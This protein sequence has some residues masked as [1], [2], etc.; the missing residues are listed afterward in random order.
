MSDHYGVSTI[1]LVGAEGDEQQ[2]VRFLTLNF[3]IRPPPAGWGDF[4][5]QRMKLFYRNYMEKFDIIAFQEVFATGYFQGFGSDLRSNFID[6]A[7]KKGF[8][9]HVRSPFY[10]SGFFKIFKLQKPVLTD[11]GLVILSR[12]PIETDDF[13]AFENSASDDEFAKKGMLYAKINI[14]GRHLHV[15]DTHMQASYEP[16]DFETTSKVRENQIFQYQQFIR[17]NAKPEEGGGFLHRISNGIMRRVSS[18]IGGN[19][20]EEEEQQQGPR[21]AV[22]V[23]GNNIHP[24]C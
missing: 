4:L 9:H 15:F 22:M 18:W 13:E 23:A 16:D 24:L 10:K 2:E 14:N 12:Y 6:A 8:E 19:N 11:A 1:L 3:F 21:P 5:E 17:K 7:K 20:A